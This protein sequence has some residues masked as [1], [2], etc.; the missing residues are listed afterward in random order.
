M[1]RRSPP[2]PVSR[3]DFAPRA[4]RL[5]S[6]V[7]AANFVLAL[8]ILVSLVSCS[9]EKMANKSASPPTR[10]GSSP[11]TDVLITPV[12]KT[13]GDVPT[14]D[15]AD[16]PVMPRISQV[17]EEPS[18]TAADEPMATAG[19]EPP[20]TSAEPPGAIA[21]EVDF[22][23]VPV[24]LGTNRARSMPPT[25]RGGMLRF[26]AETL[27]IVS[28]LVAVVA[29]VFAA[30]VKGREWGWGVIGIS[31]V[32]LTVLSMGQSIAEIL[33][34]DPQRKGMFGA[35]AGNM[36]YAECPVTIPVNAH[37]AGELESPFEF[38]VI[39]GSEH[40]ER[41]IILKHPQPI[42]QG[43][44]FS[45]VRSQVE[46]SPKKE[47]FVFIHGYNVDFSEG[48]RRAAQLAYD[49][50]FPGAAIC[51]SWP[52]LGTELGYPWDITHADLSVPHLQQFLRDIAATSGADRIYVIAH[53]MGNR[54]LTQAIET[55]PSIF[56]SETTPYRHL[57]L[58][59]PDVDRLNFLSRIAPHL[60]RCRQTVTLYCSSHDKALKAS[61]KFNGMQRAGDTIPS[62]TTYGGLFSVDCSTI[63]AGVLGHNYICEVGRVVEDLAEVFGDLP[64]GERGLAPVGHGPD[65]YW[66]FRPSEAPA[67]SEPSPVS[68]P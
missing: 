50:K 48:V 52:S 40:P 26:F 22:V 51:F 28:L 47:A 5:R 68:P 25:L 12:E 9:Q 58:A 32:V 6:G 24:L 53:S 66:Q 65:G 67:D 4:A 56:T 38:W 15:P 7:L 59:A 21:S 42:E 27:G 41:H 10:T 2:P 20:S 19:A 35:D 11:P 29:T 16:E 60:A 1:L 23:T 18:F 31:L 46:I 45:R 8:V 62:V 61:K 64:P 14:A 13:D 30:L 43:A 39:R 55:D 54:I 36:S 63:S 3:I 37:V 33:R 57:V 34:Y 49:L 44:F 17:E